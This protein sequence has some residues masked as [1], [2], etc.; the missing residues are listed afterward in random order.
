MQLQLI[1]LSMF[2]DDTTRLGKGK[3]LKNHFGSFMNVEEFLEE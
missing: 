3:N 2:A 1:S